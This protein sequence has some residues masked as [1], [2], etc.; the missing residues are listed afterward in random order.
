MKY[1]INKWEARTRTTKPTL[2]DQAGARD[3]DINIIVGQFLQHG[4]MPKGKE[5]IYGDFSNL[6]GDL[7]GFIEQG[8]RLNGLKNQLPDQLR[9]L[10]VEAL[11]A[12]TPEELKNKLT[13]PEPTKPAE[14]QK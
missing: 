8:K 13:P 9:E 1:Q 7:R 4:Q 2:T 3:T 10:S 14:E 6:P 12:L 5:P 11:L